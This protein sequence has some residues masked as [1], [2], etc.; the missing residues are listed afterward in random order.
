MRAHTYRHT[1]THITTARS[2]T[3][4]LAMYTA[5]Q[6]LLQESSNFII[7][8]C[9]YC[10]GVLNNIHNAQV[11]CARLRVTDARFSGIEARDQASLH[12]QSCAITRTGKHGISV[13]MRATALL[14][15]CMVSQTV[16]IP[17]KLHTHT[18]AIFPFPF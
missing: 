7:T 3:H 13:A 10:C 5:R 18:H 2:C 16:C 9:K 11:Q 8:F 4:A 12:L 1:H 15:D 14:E 17:C 6:R